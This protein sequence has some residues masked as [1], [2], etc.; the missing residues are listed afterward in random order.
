MGYVISTKCH[1][2]RLEDTSEPNIKII[3]G[4]KYRNNEI[5]L[6]SDVVS[7]QSTMAVFTDNPSNNEFRSLN[8]VLDT[9]SVQNTP[10]VQVARPYVQTSS[11]AQNACQF[12]VM[13]NIGRDISTIIKNN[14]NH[15][16]QQIA[17]NI[18][19]SNICKIY[20]SPTV[21]NDNVSQCVVLYI[22]NS[23]SV[24][25]NDI[26]SDVKTEISLLLD[27]NCICSETMF[28]ENAYLQSIR[29]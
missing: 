1:T 20:V 5:E 25:A 3:S 26:S 11:P 13:D 10:Y 4:G 18:G 16:N 7:G 12:F 17:N 21:V 24:N 2:Y 29:I 6:L 28:V 9:V 22:I 23:N 15:I 14:L 27:E 19:V 8:L